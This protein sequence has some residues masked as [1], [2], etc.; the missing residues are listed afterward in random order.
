[1]ISR[2]NIYLIMKANNAVPR[3][4]Y[5]KIHELNSDRKRLF[6]HYIENPKYKL[7]GW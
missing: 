7:K 6:A 4:Q 3:K 5:K 2:L 1:M